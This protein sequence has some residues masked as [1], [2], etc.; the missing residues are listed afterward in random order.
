V[1]A[2]AGDTD[3]LCPATELG[4]HHVERALHVDVLVGRPVLSH[5]GEAVG[6]HA[7]VRVDQRPEGRL[8]RSP[9][10][11]DEPAHHEASVPAQICELGRVVVGR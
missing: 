9:S 7:Q 6:L 2:V 4:Q 5:D 8:V 10:L 3:D 1:V 11:C